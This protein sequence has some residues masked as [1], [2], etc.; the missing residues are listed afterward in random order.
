M[1]ELRAS[2]EKIST[3]VF[4]TLLTLPTAPYLWVGIESG[5]SSALEPVVVAGSLVLG[6]LWLAIVLV[7]AILW[8]HSRLGNDRPYTRAIYR[9]DLVVNLWFLLKCIFHYLSRPL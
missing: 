7:F 6:L 1:A 3:C 8:A 5:Y 2:E 4:L 9:V